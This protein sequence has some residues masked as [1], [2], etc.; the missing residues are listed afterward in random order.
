MDQLL[1]AGDTQKVVPQ[2]SGQPFTTPSAGAV[3][4]A[5]VYKAVS[6]PTVEARDR[7]KSDG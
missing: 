3:A 4:T 6:K 2:S 7:L 5:S 1:G